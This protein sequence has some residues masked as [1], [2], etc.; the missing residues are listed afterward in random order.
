MK[1]TMLLRQFRSKGHVDLGMPFSQY[2][3]CRA[4]M[5]HQPLALKAFAYP[6]LIRSINGGKPGLFFHDSGV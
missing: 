1:I 4:K 5:F 6:A 2:G 3:E